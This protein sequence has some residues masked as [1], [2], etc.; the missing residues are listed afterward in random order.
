MP[1]HL[2]NH[3]VLS[4][5]PWKSPCIVLQYMNMGVFINHTCNPVKDS[6]LVTKLNIIKPCW[7]LLIIF[8]E[9]APWYSPKFTMFLSG[10]DIG[11]TVFYPLKYWNCVGSPL[12][13]WY[14]P[15][16][17]Y[18]KIN[19]NRELPWLALFRMLMF[20]FCGPVD[21]RKL[22]ILKGYCLVLLGYW[23]EAFCLTHVII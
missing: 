22:Y 10:I 14:F 23:W 6:I 13:F 9:L 7:L 8:L 3:L 4:Y 17:R 18:V 12:V 15:S 19:I 20:K 11:L 16:L 21:Y 1:Q 5:L 2:K